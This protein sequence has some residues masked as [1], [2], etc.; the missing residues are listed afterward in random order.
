MMNEIFDRDWRSRAYGE[1]GGLAR[2]WGRGTRF[3]WRPLEEVRSIFASERASFLVA[4]PLVESQHILSIL[5]FFPGSRAIWMYRHFEGVI[6]SNLK[7]FGPDP[8][9]YNLRGIID[10]ELGDH[11]F[12]EKVSDRTKEIVRR[13][14]AGDAALEDL[15]ALGWYA[16]NVIYFDRELPGNPRVRLCRYED[17]VSDPAKEMEELYRF[18]GVDF[19]GP[20]ITRFVHRK[21]VRKGRGMRLQPEIRTLCQDLLDRLDAAHRGQSG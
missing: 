9:R 17:M 12:G 14:Y 7:R 18:F 2:G 4:K 1:D 15:Q 5:D 21:S 16:R 8:I 3:R 20:Q 11:W 10:P 19:P 6:D 13:F